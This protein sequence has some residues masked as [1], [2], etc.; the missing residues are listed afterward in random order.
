MQSDRNRRRASV[1]LPT[2]YLVPA[3]TTAATY[4]L[5]CTVTDDVPR[6]S[7]FNISLTVQAPPPSFH[8]ISEINGPGTSSPLGGASV[9]TRGVVIALR[10]ATASV[11]GFY[12]E[13]QTADRDNDPNTSEGLLVFLGSTAPPACAVVGNLIQLQGSV[14]NFVSSTS[15]VGSLPLVELTGPSNC[16]VLLTNQ[17]GSLP[18]AVTIDAGN[19]LVVG[20]SAAQSRKWL[21]MRVAVPN[22]AVVGASDG[23]LTETYGPGRA[24]RR[25]LCHRTGSAAARAECRR[26][27]GYAE[28]FGRSSHRP[29]MEWQSGIPAS[30]CDRP[31]PRRNA[32]R[33]RQRIH[34][35]RTQRRDGL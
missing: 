11:R 33:G 27:P 22:A 26:H 3:N 8:T 14:S 19:P 21:G 6:S 7:G 30:Q 2:N 34:R 5:P 15:P 12:L 10:A 1:A 31:E 25:I 24:K 16:Q 23:T 9:T 13:S 17:L 18:A 29:G 20:G 28:A 32:L 35:D 4:S